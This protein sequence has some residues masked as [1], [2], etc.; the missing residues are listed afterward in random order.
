MGTDT[1][2]K[3]GAFLGTLT[4]MVGIGLL[5]MTFY[6]AYQLFQVPPAE[7]MNLSPSKPL[8]INE[9]GV[10]LLGLIFRIAMLF[11]M[12]V[13]GSVIANRGIKLFSASGGTIPHVGEREHPAPKAKN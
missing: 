2:F 8:N 4:F 11:V 3:F 1:R 6:I 12:C 7:A 13:V 10:S 5:G 9:T